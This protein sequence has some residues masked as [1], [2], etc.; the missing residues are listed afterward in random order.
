LPTIDT[1]LLL[2]FLLGLVILLFVPFGIRRGAAKE[3]MVS[4]GILFGALVATT[5]A[6]R[7]GAELVSRFG[8]DARVAPFV[9]AMAALF[10][11]VFIIGYGG[12]AALGRLPQGWMSHLI[13]GLLAVLNG[14]LLLTY[15]LTFLDEYLP[16]PRALNDG[17]VAD[18]LVGRFDLLQLAVGG[19][20]IVLVVLG[21]IVSTVRDQNQPRPL[22]AVQPAPPR[23][24][25][26]RVASDAE[27]GKFEPDAPGRPGEPSLATLEQTAPILER[28]RRPWD[29]AS[30]PGNG[31]QQ[32]SAD[33][34]TNGQ[35]APYSAGNELW[36]RRPPSPSW[37]AGTE[38]SPGA[39]ASF[40]QPVAGEA[41][42]TRCAHCGAAIGPRDL[43]CPSCG[44][45]V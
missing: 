43:F 28:P 1:P 41:H 21:I 29:E 14:A 11:G 8:V 35:P 13:G 22:A 6:D 44:K 16:A 32:W 19:G 17:L 39:Q 31:H 45:T 3:A 25:P 12:G 40:G 42:P 26:V 27:S 37:S 5:W 2:D 24:R 34:P 7:G 10:G 38:A 20:L 18:F 36:E 15:L 23:Q 9:V 4:A 33:R 30:R